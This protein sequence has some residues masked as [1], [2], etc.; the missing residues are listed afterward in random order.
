MIET[1]SPTIGSVQ[2]DL[3]ILGARLCH[4][5]HVWLDEAE[6]LTADQAQQAGALIAEL[7]RLSGQFA[8]LTD[9]VRD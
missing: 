5:G 6:S 4:M 9:E 8:R 7:D 3:R 1:E 2:L